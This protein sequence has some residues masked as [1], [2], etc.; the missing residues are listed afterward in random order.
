MKYLPITLL[1]ISASLFADGKPNILFLLSDDQDWTE[2]S[3]QIYPDIPEAKSPHMQTPNLERFALQGMR[4]SQA[5]AP[6]PVC[7]PARISLQTGKSPAQLHWTKASRPFTAADG[8]KLI[9]PQYIRNIPESEITIGE[10]L[11]S[12]GYATAHYGKWHIIGCGPEKHGYDESDGE[13]SNGDAAPHKGDNPVD[14]FGMG[15]RAAA[16]MEKSQK[17]GKPFFIQMSYHAL[18]F[19]EN[20]KPTTRAKYEKIL[21]GGN[22]KSIG[23]AA[24][25]ENLDEGVGL[26][27]E[28]IDALGIA[29]E[30]YVIYMSD[31]GG[32]GN[33]RSRPISGG[34]GDV[35]EGGI[36][37]PLIIR[38]P[39]IEANSW[40]HQAVV[41]F[42]LYNTFSE[43]AGIE[44]PAP[45]NT[46][47]GSFVHLLKGEERTIKRPRE[48]LVF[49]FPHY[50]GDTPHSAIMLGN[51]K[52]LRFYETGK[53]ELY[54]LSKDLR[55]SA[56]L[57]DRM[58]E[59]TA[60]LRERL[61]TYLAAIDAGMP[62]INPQYDPSKPPEIR[63]DGNRERNRDRGNRQNDRRQRDRN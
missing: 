59:K 44:E 21:K 54:D 42:D 24:L 4:F 22:E 2:T 25:A 31:N 19:P 8:F 5:Y 18:H 14:I 48:E 60:D 49:Q 37:V 10:R 61:D 53:L 27:L 12:A 47:G 56:N 35:K 13:T 9:P 33:S 39:G 40:S 58:P 62:E 29:D 23:R 63:R 51:Y 17:A 57:A 34:K 15:R 41:G 7:A 11:Q 30:T 3:V 50:Q 38:G 1:L 46:E 6:A 20:A 43:L 36:R 28:K 16:F 55:E 32:G 26:L 52:L 45:A